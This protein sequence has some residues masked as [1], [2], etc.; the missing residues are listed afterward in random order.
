LRIEGVAWPSQRIPTAVNL[1]F[2]DPCSVKIIVEKPKE[3]KTGSRLAECSKEGYGSEGAVLL[4]MMTVSIAVLVVVDFIIRKIF[5]FYKVVA[6]SSRQIWW[7]IIYR[8]LAQVFFPFVI[9]PTI[10]PFHPPPS[11][12]I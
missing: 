11:L 1:G 3:V 8:F 6:Y 2:L 7:G 5:L 10:I 4:M 12:S 9:H